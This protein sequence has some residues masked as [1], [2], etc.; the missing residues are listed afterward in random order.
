MVLPRKSW[1]ISQRSLEDPDVKAVLDK[2]M[3]MRREPELGSLLERY[4]P[5]VGPKQRERLL[6]F[7]REVLKWNAGINLIS[8]K[9]PA[10]TAARLLIDSLFLLEVLDG[11]GRVLD[12]GA[13][14]GF[15]SIPVGIVQEMELVLVEARRKRAAF[16]NHLVH[17]LDLQQIRVIPER[18]RDDAF[19]RDLGKFDFFWSKAA[20][21]LK[22]LFALSETCLTE[23]GRL[24]LFRSFQEKRERNT[25]KKLAESHGFSPPISRVYSCPDLFLTRTLTLC[26]KC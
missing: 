9:A 8:R 7:H 3:T 1:R 22:T 26:R 24:V 25:L 17:L 13:G 14:A 12:I 19:L 5:D 21:P 20:L 16:L 18:V 11:D 4:F 15:P 23:G 2:V 10:L 6:L